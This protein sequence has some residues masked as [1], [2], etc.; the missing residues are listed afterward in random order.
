[1]ISFSRFLARLSNTCF[2]LFLLS[3]SLRIFL[4]AATV[5][6][7][8]ESTCSKKDEPVL[9]KSVNEITHR[10][11]SIFQSFDVRVRLLFNLRESNTTQEVLLIF[12]FLLKIWYLIL[13]LFSE[14]RGTS[15]K[16]LWGWLNYQ[17]KSLIFHIVWSGF[18]LRCLM[19]K[20]PGTSKE[21]IKLPYPV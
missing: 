14:F 18:S 21:R 5:S 6:L 1:M 10:L 3:I 8:F 2:S 20:Y 9:H 13:I 12:N 15:V 7:Y 19:Q 17:Q 4:V 11:E 16:K